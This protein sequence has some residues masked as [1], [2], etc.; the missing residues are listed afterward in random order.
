MAGDAAEREAIPDA[1]RDRLSLEGGSF[2]DLDGL[3]ADIVG[4]L[5]R[6]DR[7]GAVKGDI[8]LARQPVKRA[9]VQDVMV[10]GA[11]MRA[12]VQQLQRIDAGRRRARDIADVVGAGA[13]GGEP[14]IGEAFKKRCAVLGRNLPHLEIGACG[15]M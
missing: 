13:F 5:Q 2:I 1:R 10:P 14:E 15:D 3:E 8:E 4:V 7:A 12:R 11:G 6:R 9:V